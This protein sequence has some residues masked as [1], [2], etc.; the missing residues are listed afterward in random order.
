MEAACPPA[1]RSRPRKPAS[2]HD[3]HVVGQAGRHRPAAG[4]ELLLNRGEAG[5]DARLLH[6]R[7][8][9]VGVLADHRPD[10][11]L[12]WADGGAGP[13]EAIVPVPLADGVLLAPGEKVEGRADQIPLQLHEVAARRRGGLDL[14]ALLAERWA[15]GDG[16][17]V[18]AAGD[19]DDGR[20]PGQAVR[21]GVVRRADHQVEAPP[22]RGVFPLLR[23]GDDLEGHAEGREQGLQNVQGALRAGRAGVEQ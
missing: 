18:V 21:E 20:C 7:Q 16:R 14:E 10:G 12:R 5:A 9:Q 8:Q 19:G 23:A 13:L 22:R 17:R 3:V 2:L 11:Q 1:A 4:P 15:V 6:G